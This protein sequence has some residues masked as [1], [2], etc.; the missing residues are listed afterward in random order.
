MR[1]SLVLL[2]GLIAASGIAG[3]HGRP[4]GAGSG[5][6]S[7]RLRMEILPDRPE[8][9]TFPYLALVTRTDP[10]TGNVTNTCAGALVENG[11][12]VLTARQCTQFNGTDTPLEQLKVYIGGVWHD[13]AKVVA[14]S[15]PANASNWATPPVPSNNLAVLMLMSESAAAPAKLPFDY[16]SS[17]PATPAP[18]ENDRVWAAALGVTESFDDKYTTYY[19]MDVRTAGTCAAKF[20][21]TFCASGTGGLVAQAATGGPIVSVASDAQ[22]PDVLVGVVGW[23]QEISAAYFMRITDKQ[24]FLAQA[25]P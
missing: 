3:A 22:T 20:T 11:W 8:L 19:G 24:A 16:T 6:Y 1:A 4:S 10:A 5:K 7:R 21:D 25:M 23:S 9:Q 18:A 2:V 14:E 15:G 17:S 13:V 12:R